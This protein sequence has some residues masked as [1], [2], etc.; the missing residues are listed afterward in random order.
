M[1]AGGDTDVPMCAWQGVAAQACCHPAPPPPPSPS[2]IQTASPAGPREQTA[3]AASPQRCEGLRRRRPQEAVAQPP[4]A[5]AAVGPATPAAAQAV[6]VQQA[7]RAE[8]TAAAARRCQARWPR[9]AS[10]PAEHPV[11]HR[12]WARAP[13]AAAPPQG[14]RRAGQRC[15]GSQ[16][17]RRW[18]P[19][20]GRR[21]HCS[22]RQSRL[23]RLRIQGRERAVS[24]ALRAIREAAIREA[25]AAVLAAWP[26]ISIA[27]MA[28]APSRCCS[29]TCLLCPQVPAA[30]MRW[31]PAPLAAQER[32]PATP[33]AR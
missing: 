33:A 29:A 6:Q 30:Q 14:E 3:G 26:P 13:R 24:L 28:W 7:R 21:W 17:L 11:P 25:A 19:Q 20:P 18:R 16:D 8:V 4:S 10:L 15:P 31:A 1:W 22:R 27:A 23:A 5:V 32:R 2:P 9:L 12:R